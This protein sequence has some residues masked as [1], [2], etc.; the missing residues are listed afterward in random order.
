MDSIPP[1][2]L[3]NDKQRGFLT[4][5]TNC[6]LYTPGVTSLWLTVCG[7]EIFVSLFVSRVVENQGKSGKMRLSGRQ[8][9]G[10]EV[11]EGQMFLIEY[12]ILTL[13]LSPARLPIPPHRHCSC[14]IYPANVFFQKH[15]RHI[16]KEAQDVRSAARRQVDLRRKSGLP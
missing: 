5:N 6:L 11:F 7:Q 1:P 3:C 9:G 4:T 12:K 16:I 2:T 14:L 10:N 13:L 15:P 8:V